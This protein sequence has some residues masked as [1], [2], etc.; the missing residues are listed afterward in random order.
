MQ[1]NKT[2]ET[3]QIKKAVADKLPLRVDKLHAFIVDE[4]AFCDAL[5]IEEGSPVA[6]MGV[7]AHKENDAWKFVVKGRPLDEE[8][9]EVVDSLPPDVRKEYEDWRVSHL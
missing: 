3:E 6:S 5:E 8:W 1:N 4:W 7:I 9:D 2:F